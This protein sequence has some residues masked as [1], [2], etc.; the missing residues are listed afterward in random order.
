VVEVPVDPDDPLL[1]SAMAAAQRDRAAAATVVNI[2][3][4][5]IELRCAEGPKGLAPRDNNGWFSTLVPKAQPRKKS[6]T[7]KT[8]LVE[9]I[10]M[11]FDG[12]GAAAD[13]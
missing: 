13:C 6:P 3:I 2:V 9:G 5:I 1:A 10:L 11:R 4:R 7:T 12:S 8:G